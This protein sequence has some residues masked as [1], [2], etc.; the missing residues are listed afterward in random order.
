MGLN[1]ANPS[2]LA[3]LGLIAVPIIV[4]LLARGEYRIIPVG[5]LRWLQAQQQSRWS[6]VQLHDPWRLLLRCLLVTTA[7]LALAQ[8]S[9]ID[10]SPTPQMHV[11]VDP[12]GAAPAIGEAL[13]RLTDEASEQGMA[14][15]VRALAPGLPSWE[16][17]GAPVNG[18]LLYPLLRKADAELS[19]GPLVVLADAQA[20]RLGW[21]RPTL[22]R[23]VRWIPVPAAERP[24]QAVPEPREVA[25]VHDARATT[26]AWVAAAV[27]AWAAAG[28]R[29]DDQVVVYGLE[30]MPD[31]LTAD[32]VVWLGQEDAL[33]AP[34]A[35]AAAADAS[36]LRD[37]PGRVGQA[38]LSL[39][40]SDG[41]PL[42]FMRVRAPGADE[43][44]LWRA[45]SGEV[46]LV[47]E[48]QDGVLRLLGPMNERADGLLASSQFPI[49]L[50]DWFSQRWRSPLPTD[51]AVS[52][53]QAV[54]T[55]DIASSPAQ[56]SYPLTNTLLTVVLLLWL[57]ERALGLIPRPREEAAA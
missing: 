46:V 32:W 41:L 24:L 8:P 27:R 15:A 4:H 50:F 2:A 11:L 40:S 48:A 54:P 21:H 51:L 33:P 28:R 6:R 53:A 31:T 52:A 10:R 29:V 3:L 57:L 37:T 22:S 20:H 39:G 14:L 34:G 56:I 5:S 30:Q 42:S 45:D 18:P 36:V 38:G 19:P 47:R 7:V 55:A 43:V 13:A 35:A 12:S 44:P 23:Q 25:V 16:A 1:F 17:E 49:L 26:A 9:W